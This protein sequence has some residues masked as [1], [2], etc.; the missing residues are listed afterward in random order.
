MMMSEG[1]LFNLILILSGLLTAAK[2]GSLTVLALTTFLI[3]HSLGIIQF[4]WLAVRRGWHRDNISKKTAFISAGTSPAFTLQRLDLP[5][6]E[7][8]AILTDSVDLADLEYGA[9]IQ[10]LPRK[11]IR[12]PVD[13]ISQIAVLSWRWDFVRS[14]FGKRSLNLAAAIRYA[15]SS[16]VR[17]L[18]ADCV[19]IDQTLKPRDLIKEVTQFS[20]LY[21]KIPVIAAYDMKKAELDEIMFRPWIFSEIRLMKRNRTRITYV[22]HNRQGAYIPRSTFSFFLGRVPQSRAGHTNF[23]KQL[24]KCWK[25]DFATSALQILNARND[26]ARVTD[27]KFIIP[28]LAK[29]LLA[30]E[31]LQRNDYLLT[32]ALLAN[33]VNYESDSLTQVT[34]S[35]V[36]LLYHQYRIKSNTYTRVSNPAAWRPDHEDDSITVLKELHNV[37]LQGQLVAT[38]SN[39][40]DPAEHE[41]VPD[42]HLITYPITE[43]IILKMLGLHAAARSQYFDQ[44]ESRRAF[45]SRLSERK[46]PQLNIVAL[47]V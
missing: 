27:F 31:R 32:V 47:R 21:T 46:K 33:A 45:F 38:F 34:D 36:D 44:E 11:R 9:T 18:F 30:A 8:S 17:Y 5:A 41:H 14:N 28:P 6:W 10:D 23:A 26:M 43:P 7:Y 42:Y 15:K 24:D 20:V 19:S 12:L 1:G 40:K 4:C 29:V 35:F 13:D 25:S 37:Y 22:G 39:Q 3:G 16:G 2:S